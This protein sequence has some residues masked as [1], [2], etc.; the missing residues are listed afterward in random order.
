MAAACGFRAHAVGVTRPAALARR[1]GRATVSLL[2]LEDYQRTWTR[3]RHFTD[4]RGADD[5][6]ALWIVEHPP[7]Y[8]QGQAGKA[9]H[10]LA[11]GQVPVVQT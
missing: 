7:V 3:M 1:R 6:D 10:L 4:T 9:E 2:G 5:A 11:P 8:T